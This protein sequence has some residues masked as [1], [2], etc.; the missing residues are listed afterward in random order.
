M[1]D[2]W[3]LLQLWKHLK[4]LSWINKSSFFL[5]LVCWI[6]YFPKCVRSRVV[7]SIFSNKVNSPNSFFTKFFFV[8]LAT[9]GFSMWTTLFGL[10][11]LYL[12]TPIPNPTS[13]GISLH[14]STAYP[15]PPPKKIAKFSEINLILTHSFL[16]TASLWNVKFI[17]FTGPTNLVSTKESRLRCIYTGDLFVLKVAMDCDVQSIK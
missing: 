8:A 6:F 10:M 4:G 11:E 9:R 16:P 12:L 17:I 5:Y 3:H 1:V 15:P 2:C 13:W 14:R 7:E